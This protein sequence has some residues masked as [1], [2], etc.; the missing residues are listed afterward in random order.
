[1]RPALREYLGGSGGNGA[2][3]TPVSIPNTEV[4]RRSGDDS[5]QVRQ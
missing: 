5:A 2:A 4:K 3:G 1:M